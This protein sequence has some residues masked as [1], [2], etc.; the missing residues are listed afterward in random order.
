MQKVTEE[1][2]SAFYKLTDQAGGETAQ[3]THVHHKKKKTARCAASI[4]NLSHPLVCS[5]SRNEPG[6]TGSCRAQTVWIN[7][8][9]PPFPPV[10]QL[11]ESQWVQVCSVL[12]TCP[13]Q[14]PLRDTDSCRCR[15]N[16]LRGKMTQNSFRNA[17]ETHLWIRSSFQCEVWNVVLQ[18]QPVPLT[19][20]QPIRDCTIFSSTKEVMWQPAVICLSDRLLSK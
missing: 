11:E 2:F 3:S 12:Q 13:P 7:F 16:I 4:I 17:S 6:E 8:Y 18:G 9:S 10:K 14:G 5:D 15:N 20:N 19:T 1:R